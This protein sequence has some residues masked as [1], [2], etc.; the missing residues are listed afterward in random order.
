LRVFKKKL[1]RSRIDHGGH[2]VAPGKETCVGACEDSLR[3][4]VPAMAALG[5]RR[6]VPMLVRAPRAHVSL[7]H[8][9][10]LSL[11]RVHAHGRSSGLVGHLDRV[12]RCG[13][14]RC[15]AIL[16]SCS[17]MPFPASRATACWLRAAAFWRH[18]L[19][20]CSWEEW[21]AMVPHN[22]ALIPFVR[23]LEIDTGFAADFYFIKLHH[24]PWQDW[25]HIEVPNLKTNKAL[26][27]S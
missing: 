8:G 23:D 11:T 2:D 19:E 25:V 20:V 10:M 12:R 13:L 21:L 3:L 26:A 22:S 27:Y 5:G 16:T 9:I 24:K 1:W 15:D 18:P 7:G 4:C 6:D 14:C 17:R